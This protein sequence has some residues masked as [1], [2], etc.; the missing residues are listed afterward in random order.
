MNDPRGEGFLASLLEGFHSLPRTGAG[1]AWADEVQLLQP[2][3]NLLQGG[4]RQ[5]RG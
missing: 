4:A 3:H 2:G 1:F 5:P